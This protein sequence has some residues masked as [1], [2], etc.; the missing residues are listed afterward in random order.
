VP[1]VLKLIVFSGLPGTGKTRLAEAIGRRLGIPV[2]SVAWLLGALAPFGVLRRQDRGSMAYGLITAL[3][4][5]QLLLGQSAI[6]DGMAG[7]EE[8]RDCWRSL[9]D[10]H[11]ARFVAVECVCSDQELQRERIGAR[12]DAVPGWPDPGWDHVEAMRSRYEA[13]TGERLLVDAV[14]PY[15]QN[16]AE[17]EHYIIAAPT[18]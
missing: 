6:V 4:E 2:F 15:E 16:L 1:L 3:V 8:V 17:V 11:D 7:S 14:M 5:H 9:A 13:W 10:Q 12:N 18:S